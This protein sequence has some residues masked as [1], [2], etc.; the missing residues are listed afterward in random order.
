[1]TTMENSTPLRYGVS[2]LRDTL[3]RSAFLRRL[4]EK[5]LWGRIV[6][7]TRAA[8]VFACEPLEGSE[9]VHL[10]H[11][12]RS[13]DHLSVCLSPSEKAHKIWS[14]EGRVYKQYE[15]RITI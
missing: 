6:P 8:L 5:I 12:L 9:C 15:C 11:V 3:R 2:P 13:Q 7:E 1:M 10:K 4:G 14:I